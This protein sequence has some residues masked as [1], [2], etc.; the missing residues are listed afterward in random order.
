MKSLS[1]LRANAETSVELL[2]LSTVSADVKDE[3]RS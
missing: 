1:F 3:Q 2:I